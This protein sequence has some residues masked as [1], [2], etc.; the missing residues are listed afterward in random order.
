MSKAAAGL[1]LSA[2]CG[3]R[4]A[5]A[6]AGHDAERRVAGEAAVL[7]SSAEC[8]LADHG[9]AVRRRAGNCRT[10]S[11]SECCASTAWR[12][13]TCCASAIAR[14]AS[15]RRSKSNR[16]RRTISCRSSARIRT[17]ARSSSTAR[18]RRRRFAATRCR[19]VAKLSR[20]FRYVRSAVDE[21]RA[22][23]AELR[24]ETGGL[25]GRYAR[26]RSNRNW[27]VNHGGTESTENRYDRS[28][29][30]GS[31]NSRIRQSSPCL[32]ALRGEFLIGSAEQF[33]RFAEHP[34]DAFFV[35]ELA[36]LRRACTSRPRAIRR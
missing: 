18:R 31:Y 36:A 21:P 22:R 32:R 8:V 27:N 16:N 3:A 15:I 25:A 5:R 20:E 19:L 13:G 29:I 33:Q 34:Q 1:Q 9:P 35:G 23:G 28:T 6:R 24:A 2:D 7:R 30:N 12:C 14:G 26:A 4:C 11:G 10:T 17:S